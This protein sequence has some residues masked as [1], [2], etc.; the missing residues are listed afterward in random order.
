MNDQR[1]REHQ[2]QYRDLYFVSLDDGQGLHK[3]L[4]RRKLITADDEIC[5]LERAGE[6]NMNCTL[7]VQ[8]SRQSLIVKQSRPWVE[9]FPTILAPWD[10]VLSEA[11]FYMLVSPGASIASRMPRLLHLDSE[12]RIMVLEDLGPAQDYTGIYRGDSLSG[13]TASALAAWLSELHAVSFQTHTRSCLRNIEMRKLNHEHIF[14]IPLQV[15][16]GLELDKITPGLSA[17]AQRLIDDEGLAEQVRALGEIYLS[18]GAAILHGDFFPGSWLQGASGP[19]VIDP[20]FAF[21]GKPE[22]D[23][24]VLIAHLYIAHQ[25]ESVHEACLA[26]YRTQERFNLRLALRF[27]GVEITRRLIGLAQLP[28][29]LNLVE[30]QRLLQLAKTLVSS[31][32][33]LSSPQVLAKHQLADLLQNDSDDASFRCA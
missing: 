30:K 9:K 4:L 29:D 21:F 20:E 24:G 32:D 5:C 12:S 3:Y 33:L 8:T 6:G 23:L 22:F 13:E 18:D 19:R 14:R 7:R 2:L 1:L 17:A 16:N 10:R 31:T 26:A 28:V 15:N 27:S 11:R 25:G